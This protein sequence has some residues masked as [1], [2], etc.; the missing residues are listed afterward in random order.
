[1]N[2]TQSPGG[3]AVATTTACSLLSVMVFAGAGCLGDPPI[4]ERWSRIEITNE[5]STLLVTEGEAA[6]LSVGA[7][8]TYREIL[9]GALVA[10]V[11]VSDTLTPADVDFEAEDWR[12]RAA[13]VDLVLR[14]S[15]S[16]GF[17]SR[18]TTGFDHLMVDFNLGIEAAG[19]TPPMPPE[20]MADSSAVAGPTTGLFLLVYFGDVEE[21]RLEDGSEIDVVT[22]FFS[23][24]YDILAAGRVLQSPAQP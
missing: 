19:V 1:M 8:L 3:R 6:P 18:A 21:V 2:G 22:P 15:R 23:D 20:A 4:E 17:A 12:Q 11:R 7:R 9:T 10:E 16:L 5:P 24:D 14:N 13:D